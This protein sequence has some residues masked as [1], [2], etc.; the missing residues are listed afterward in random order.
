MNRSVL[1]VL[2]VL[3]VVGAGLTIFLSD[4]EDV[5]KNDQAIAKLMDRAEYP[6]LTD[7]A[8]ST[9][10]D[11]DGHDHEESAE[12][13][14]ARPIPASSG[15]YPR[16]EVLDTS[17]NFGR[18]LLNSEPGKH[19]FTIKNVGEADLELQAGEAT[20]QCTTFDVDK[21]RIAPGEEAVVNIQWKAE[22]RDPMFRHGGPVFTN[23]PEQPEIKFT[24]TG[25]IDVAVELLPSDMWDAGNVYM[26]RGA[27]LRAAVAS[28][29]LDEFEVESIT[30]DSEFVSFD[31]TPMPPEMLASENWLSGYSVNVTVSENIPGGKFEEEVR[32]KLSCADE[33]LIIP[34]SARKHGRIRYL[35][36]TGTFFDPEMML[37]KFGTF[38]STES[39]S[40]KILLIVD[41]AGMQEPLQITDIE[42]SPSF[43]KASLEQD[44]EQA[45]DKRR[46]FLKI[47]V[48]SGKPRVQYSLSNLAKLRIHTNHPEGEII[49]V[50]V[51]FSTN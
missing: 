21:E 50:D 49:P 2:G 4:A 13:A 8:Q 42:A 51:F 9:H 45:G 34:L 25:K 1:I 20:C 38:P 40:G 22:R 7:G 33:K 11:H 24:I 32:I 47:E 6:W 16:V 36:T 5:D 14:K 18:Q 10:S 17:Y 29:M 44:G 26:D 15:P 28:S 27:T 31:V 30:T 35:P 19:Q 37:L 48:P 39:R 43:L 46:Y 3:A 23:D 41:Q 12:P